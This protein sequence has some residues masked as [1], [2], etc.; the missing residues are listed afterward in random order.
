MST[1]LSRSRTRR[2]AA[3]ATTSLAVVA[4]ST[5]LALSGGQGSW[6]AP[7][8]MPVTKTSATAK[9]IN[10]IKPARRGIRRGSFQ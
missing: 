8:E 3:V 2:R 7:A 6:A 4:S 1:P 10:T 5:L 9:P